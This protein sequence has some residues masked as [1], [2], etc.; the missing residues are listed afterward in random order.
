MTDPTAPNLL[1][2]IISLRTSVG[3]GLNDEELTRL[4]CQEAL[5]SEDGLYLRVPMRGSN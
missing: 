2:G 4:L 5:P 3:D 1:G